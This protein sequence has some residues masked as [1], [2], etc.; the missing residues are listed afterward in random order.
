[1]VNVCDDCYIS[2]VLHILVVY[3][4]ARAHCAYYE[5]A[6]K[7]SKNSRHMQVLC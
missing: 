5:K 2:D 7:I 6:C 4:Y 1:M 3:L